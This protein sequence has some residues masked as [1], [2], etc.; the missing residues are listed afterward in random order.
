MKVLKLNKI[1]LIAYTSSFVSF[2][3]KDLNN[4]VK[5]IILFGSVARGE[6]DK[7]SDID[8]FFNVNKEDIKKVENIVKKS[9][10]KFYKS[11]FYETWKLKGITK[12]ISIKV[13][14]LDKW[15]LKRSILSDGIILY[16]KYKEFPKKVKHYMLI[17][18]KPIKNITKRNRFIR[19]LIGR[20]EKNYST[21]GFLEDIK[22]K[23]ISSRVILTPVENLKETLDIFNKEK[24]DYKIFE[25]WSDQ[26]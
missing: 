9:L 2:I 22:G 4:L 15:K 24:I 23:I 18:H 12:N 25:I 11:K 16:G 14:V 6:F 10:I 7:K 26:F 8:L 17:V 5:E 20:K 3:L 21:K 19:K 13:G 1:E